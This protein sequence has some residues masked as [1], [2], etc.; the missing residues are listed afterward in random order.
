MSDEWSCIVMVHAPISRTIEALPINT[1][2]PATKSMIRFSTS[3]CQRFEI[4]VYVKRP[5]QSDGMFDLFPARAPRVRHPHKVY[6][7]DYAI[8]FFWAVDDI[9]KA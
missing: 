7:I 6:M 1:Q 9:C 3:A 8:L 4:A 5:V 2:G